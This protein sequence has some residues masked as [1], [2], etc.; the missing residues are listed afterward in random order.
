[1][2]LRFREK[3][4]QSRKNYSIMMKEK[5]ADS[6]QETEN[7]IFEVAVELRND[8]ANFKQGSR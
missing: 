4:L 7:C 1:M 6:L 8:E 3:D 2:F 5:A